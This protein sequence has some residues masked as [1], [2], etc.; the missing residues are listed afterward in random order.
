MTTGGG[1]GRVIIAPAHLHAGNMDLTGDLERLYGT[2]GFTIDYPRTIIEAVKSDKITVRG[3]D[4]ENAER[5]VGT[6]MERFN[7]EGGI[8]VNVK[9]T[10]PKHLGMGSQTALALSIGSAISELYNRSVAVEEMSI[11]LGRSDIVALGFNSFQTGGFIVDGGYKIR[12]KGRRVPPCIF[13]C[14]IP[15]DWL[16]VVCIPKKPIPAI[17]EIKEHEKE[18]LNTL[19][20]MPEQMSDRLSRLMLMQVMPSIVEHDIKSFGKYITAFNSRLGGFW[21]E[22][23]EGNTYCDPV[24][25]TGINI[26]LDNGAY[27]A[28]QTCWGPTF[29]GIVDN[30]DIARK[31]VEKLGN[32]IESEGGGEVFYT[33]GN[34]QGARIIKW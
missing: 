28:C 14:P 29:Y 30:G 2:A 31:L 4:T 32:L 33:P 16:F 27:G 6:F 26:L 18:I 5:Y 25:E 24:V 12:E 8:E 20:P 3:E 34:N 17:L 22:F 11:A 19:K 21:E 13:R 23:Q 9:E 1:I 7:V 15:E 10:I